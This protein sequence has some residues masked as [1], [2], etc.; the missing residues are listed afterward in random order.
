[1]CVAVVRHWALPYPMLQFID[2]TSPRNA[3]F[4]VA[5]FLREGSGGFVY[6]LLWL[7]ALL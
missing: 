2:C 1:M 5:L 6:S 3:C 4:V 7:S